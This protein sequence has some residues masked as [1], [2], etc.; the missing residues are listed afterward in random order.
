MLGISV[1]AQKIGVYKARGRYEGHFRS[2]SGH[3]TR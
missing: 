3:P 1:V 2:F